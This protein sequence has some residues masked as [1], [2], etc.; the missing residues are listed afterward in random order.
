[1]WHPLG[2]GQWS[3]RAT[4]VGPSDGTAGGLFD[5]VEAMCTDGRM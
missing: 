4:T 3:R 1:M 5:T 2:D